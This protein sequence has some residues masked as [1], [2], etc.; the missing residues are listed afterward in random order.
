VT[1]IYTADRESPYEEELRLQDRHSNH[2]WR[3]VPLGN[4]VDG[5]VSCALSASVHN[6]FR[7]RLP[8]TSKEVRALLSERERRTTGRTTV[9][10][11]EFF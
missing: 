3:G 11:P 2:E 7:V 5:S 10:M 4:L 8:A 6:D 1:A 9:G